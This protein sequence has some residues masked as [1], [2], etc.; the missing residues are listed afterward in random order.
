MSQQAAREWGQTIANVA[1]NS[2][3][4]FLKGEFQS[5]RMEV[6]GAKEVESGWIN[7]SVKKRDAWHKRLE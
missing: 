2:S 4:D 1:K 5:I 3:L 7:E 6:L